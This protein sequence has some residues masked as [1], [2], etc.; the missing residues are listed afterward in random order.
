MSYVSLRCSCGGHVYRM[1]RPWWVRLI[2][3]SRLYACSK[4]LH[5]KVVLYWQRLIPEKFNL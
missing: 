3:Y 5:S 2:P 1:P 4:C